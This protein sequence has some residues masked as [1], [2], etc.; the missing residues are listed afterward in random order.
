MAYSQN[1]TH[2]FQRI[3]LKNVTK[4]NRFVKMNEGIK[5]LVKQVCTHYDYTQK[6]ST[7][8]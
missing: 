4:K 5:I 8:S 7:M 2:L 6:L 3:K 1:I